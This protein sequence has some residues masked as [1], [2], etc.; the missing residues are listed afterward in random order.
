MLMTTDAAVAPVLRLLLLE[1]AVGEADDAPATG[2]SRFP[3]FDDDFLLLPV[4]MLQET[5]VVVDKSACGF[6]PFL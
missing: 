6:I 1:L 4:S 2:C 3:R 5:L